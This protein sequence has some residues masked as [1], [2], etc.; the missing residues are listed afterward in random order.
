MAAIL[1]KLKA[2]RQFYSD[3]KA[4]LANRVIGN[5]LRGA[6]KYAGLSQTEVFEAT[7]I[8]K[9]RLSELENGHTTMD[10]YTLIILCDLYGCSV[11]YVVGRSCE[12][13]NDIYASHVNNVMLNTKNYL[14]PIVA[15]MTEAVVGVIKKIDK[16]EHLELVETCKKLTGYLLTNGEQVKNFDSDLHRLLFHIEFQIR[17]IKIGEARR[18]LAM[19]AQLEAIRERHDREDGHLLLS[20]IERRPQM[21][22]PLPEPDIEYIEIGESEVQFD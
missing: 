2:V 18:E 19:A 5:N 22:L 1:S 3:S 10:I 21:S 17:K 4:K 12:P 20:D 9:N 15:E 8:R 11:D 14:E 6:R 16:D 13:I 7:G